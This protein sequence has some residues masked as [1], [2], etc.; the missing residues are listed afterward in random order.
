MLTLFLEQCDKISLGRKAS[1]LTLSLLLVILLSLMRVEL[2]SSFW[3]A[4]APSLDPRLAEYAVLNS[5]GLAT[6]L[7]RE[8][9]LYPESMYLHWKLRGQRHGFP[10]PYNSL[11]INQGVWEDKIITPAYFR[12]M[13]PTTKKAYCE[14][15]ISK[16]PAYIISRDLDVVSCL[17]GDLLRTY[18]REQDVEAPSLGEHLS[19]P[20]AIF[21]RR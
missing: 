7:S 17:E 8:G 2:F 18:G 19:P 9:F 13:L 15:L 21:K 3:E 6:E 11:L 10:N 1:F 4:M 16:G 20:L 5:S 12:S 14:M